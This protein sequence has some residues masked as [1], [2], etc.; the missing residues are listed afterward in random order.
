MLSYILATA[1][2]AKTTATRNAKRPARAL[3]YACFLFT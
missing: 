3:T 2:G 1:A